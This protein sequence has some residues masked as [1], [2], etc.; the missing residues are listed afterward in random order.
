VLIV[1]VLY[2][3]IISMPVLILIN[4]FRGLNINEI[5]ELIMGKFFGKAASLLFVVF[6]LF[7]YTACMLIGA[8][9]ISISVLPGT[10]PWAILLLAYVTAANIT[11]KGAGTIGRVA[12]FI[13]PFVM[14]TVVLFFLMG[15]SMMDF[16]DQ[17][18]CARGFHVSRVNLGAFYTAARYR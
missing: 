15:L 13:I 7:C 5:T 16:Q 1:A 4:K 18:S 10:P 6:L 3:L 12:S 2:I 8:I 11:F 9:S 17:T 14:F